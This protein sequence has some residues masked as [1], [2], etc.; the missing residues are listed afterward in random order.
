[1]IPPGRLFFDHTVGAPKCKFRLLFP[2]G[3][4]DKLDLMQRKVFAPKP[5]RFPPTAILLGEFP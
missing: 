4:F 2:I 1:M 3:N 5:R